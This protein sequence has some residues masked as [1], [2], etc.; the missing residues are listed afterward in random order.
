MTAADPADVLRSIRI[1][2][3]CR[4]EWDQM[5]LTSE[6]GWGLEQG[7]NRGAVRFCGTCRKAV[8][9]LS[10]MTAAEAVATVQRQEETFCI[11]LFRRPDGTVIHRDCLRG[12]TRV[13][14]RL[15]RTGVMLLCVAGIGLASWLVP[16]LLLNGSP[17][18]GRIQNG[19]HALI[20][21]LRTMIGIS[22]PNPPVMGGCAPPPIVPAVPAGSAAAETEGA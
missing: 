4:A 16:H 10:A 19:W 3:P 13:A 14:K 2:S 22:R 17:M 20:G 9:D 21:E 1:A 7:P 5:T 11:R 18:S 12:V 6:E 15:A 8:Y